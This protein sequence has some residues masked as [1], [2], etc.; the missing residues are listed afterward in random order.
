[1]ELDWI[2]RHCLSLPGTT[3]NVQW[4]SLLFRIGGKIYALAALEESASVALRFKCT[5]E[6]F[7]ELVE[8]EGLIQAPYF[9]RK[10]WIAMT[11]LDALPRAE[12]RRRINRSYELV[13]AKLPKK[14]RDT[15]PEGKPHQ[16]SSSSSY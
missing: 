7:A 5:P 4:E 8:I 13:K 16:S 6:E 2:R 10:Q 12:T 9:A 1:M 11:T 14:I 15:L 3:E